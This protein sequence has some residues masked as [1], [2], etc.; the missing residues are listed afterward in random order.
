MIR[1]E[2]FLT[3]YILFVVTFVVNS[4]IGTIAA[5]LLFFKLVIINIHSL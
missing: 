4:Y 3:V 1:R 5:L 2:A